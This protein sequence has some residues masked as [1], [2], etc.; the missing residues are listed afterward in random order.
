M[1]SKTGVSLLLSLV[2]AAGCSGGSAGGSRTPTTPTGGSPGTGGD[3]GSGGLTGGS[4]P[5]SPTGGAP[6][7]G[8]ESGGPSADA[9]PAAAPD[10][11]AP[12]SDGAPVTGGGPS[13]EPPMTPDGW[14]QTLGPNQPVVG[15]AVASEC[16]DDPTAG[17]TEFVGQFKI[18]KPYDLP[19]T[20]RFKFA[21][22]IYTIFVKKGDKAHEPGNGTRERTE[23]RYQDMSSGVQL[24]SGDFFLHS[25]S[26]HV[27]VF[28]VKNAGPPTGVYLRVD[29]GTMH[30]LHGGN[31]L[32]NMY[33]KWFNMKIL[34]DVAAGTGKV[35]INNCLKETVNMPR[36]N[37]TW[38]FKH[39]TY[40]CD[41]DVCTADFKN[42]H[43]YKK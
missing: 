39:G 29:N 38:Y 27:C 25:P 9:G 24:W 34:V 18:Q 30:E 19:E 6:G 21:D 14:H 35:Y 41:S 13:A 2:V 5:S 12:A 15:P 26:Q 17:M 23:A 4:G 20:D 36:G 16:P 10:A 42:I 3:I 40:T 7:T 8:G 1:Y 22:G 43:L 32:T 33:D 31:V 11:S 37:G 28:Q